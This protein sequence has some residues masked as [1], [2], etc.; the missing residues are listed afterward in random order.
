MTV[1]SPD[2]RTER[3]TLMVTGMTCAACSGR[4]QR[5]LEREEGVRSAHV[6]LM[7]GQAEIVYQPDVVSPDA[8]V[9]VVTAT[10]YGAS[11]P[12]PGSD[13]IADTEALD[14]TRSDELHELASKLKF[15]VAVAILSMVMM[16]FAEVP[17]AMTGDPMM[18][19]IAPLADGLRS[20]VPALGQL[21]PSAWRW[22]LLALTLPTVLWAGRHFYTR[23]WAAFRHHSADMNTLIA[24]GTGAALVFSIAMTVGGDWFG[25]HGIRPVVYY[26]AVNTIIALILVGNYLETR[27]KRQTTGAIRRLIGLRPKTARIRRNGSDHE[28]ALEDVQVG[29]EVIVRPG[30]RVPVDGEV[31][32]GRSS[33]DEAMLTGEP[34]PVGKEPGDEVTGGTV[35][36]TG[37]VVFRATRVGRDT[38][39]ANIIRMVQEAQGSR[40][41]IQALADRVSAVFVPVVISIAIATFVVWFIMAP[42]PS[43]GVRA[44][45]AAVTVLIIACPCAMGLAVPTAV[46]VATGRG[47][48]RG[49]LIKGGEPLQRV[50]SLDVVVLDKTGTITEGRPAVA[51]MR[52]AEGVDQAEFLRLAASIERR[53]EHPLAEAIVRSAQE[54][55]VTLHEPESFE[56]VPGKGIRGRVEG[57]DVLVGTVRFLEEEGVETLPFAT[58]AK[59]LSAQAHTPVA[60]AV[61]GRLVGLL[62]IADPVRGTSRD[63]VLAL[64]DLDLDVVMLTGDNRYTAEVVSHEVGIGTV[65]AEVLPDRKLDEVRALQATGQVVAMVGDGINDA[66]ALAAADV[67]IALGSGTDVAIESADITLI[68]GDLMGVARVVKLCRQTMAVMR[69]NLFWAF[70]YNV[71]GIPVAAGVLYPAFGILLT[72]TMA[73]TAMAVSS[74]SVVTNSLRLR[75]AA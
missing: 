36:L 1:A 63:A 47:A 55:G 70:A 31:L 65:I 72:P 34:L 43:S 22:I 61:N 54:G 19:L 16:P 23:A 45:A 21:H 57:S 35:N 58:V 17:D 29:D 49:L 60:V 4:V 8:L 64:Q 42:P 15:A 13:A 30:E 26:E 18:R 59:E 28:V 73:A 41:P 37:A 50:A 10:G 62:G 40:A 39:L 52:V 2:L 9:S 67:G 12:A 3:S 14:R 6:N 75:K 27:A 20:L 66:P 71:I 56:A 5:A 7:T 24:V 25:A 33:I 68:S 51:V 48:E 69:Q 74:V 44:L 46:M 32:E 53:S 38:V 11:V